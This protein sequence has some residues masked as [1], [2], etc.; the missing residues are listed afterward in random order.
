M[1]VINTLLSQ[2]AAAL[3]L[4]NTSDQDIA[5]RAAAWSA[6]T[7]SALI[8]KKQMDAERQNLKKAGLAVGSSTSAHADSTS[9]A[10]VITELRVI[11]DHLEA[12]PSIAAY[13]QRY[14]ASR[15]IGSFQPLGTLS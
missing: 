7:S 15:L 11:A 9:T 3:T 4:P 14:E 12:L 6:L 1:G 2:H 8:A 13:A 5:A 10:Y